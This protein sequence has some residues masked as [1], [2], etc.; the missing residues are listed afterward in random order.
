MMTSIP[1]L[2]PAPDFE[3]V[4]TAGRPV[5]LSGYRGDRHVV[6]VFSRGFA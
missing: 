1:D 2:G 5:R 4:D 3:L 6:L